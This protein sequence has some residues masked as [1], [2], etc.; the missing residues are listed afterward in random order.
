MIAIALILLSISLSFGVCPGTLRVSL[1][2]HSETVEFKGSNYRRADVLLFIPVRIDKGEIR[3]LSGVRKHLNIQRT[4]SI[5]RIRV[6]ISSITS[7][8]IDN[9]YLKQE[10]P[11]GSIFNE[12]IKARKIISRNPLIVEPINLYPTDRKRNSF[13]VKMPP[14]KPGESIE[15]SYTIVSV[16]KVKKP[17]LFGDRVAVKKE[18]DPVYILVGKYS[19][20]FPFASSR[21]QDINLEN[22]REVILN[23]SEA[24]LNPIVKIFGIAD[25]KT[26]NRAKN[27]RVARARARFV[28][29][30]ILG[31]NFACY[32]RRG[33]AEA[34]TQGER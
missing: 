13:I 18:S 4:G 17:S 10:L 21:T 26:T 27:E 23:L 34:P 7:K 5:Q 14:I 11:E 28:A 3:T 33:F 16:K 30:E 25:G 9:A 29:T 22:I 6:R 24:G 12:S 8:T 31:K 2:L 1:D 19:I 15:L 32:V 20:K